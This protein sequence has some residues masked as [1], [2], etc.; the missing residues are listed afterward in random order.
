MAAMVQQQLQ[1]IFTLNMLI[2]PLKYFG[3]QPSDVQPI[4]LDNEFIQLIY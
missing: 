2:R 3:K 1:D 4:T